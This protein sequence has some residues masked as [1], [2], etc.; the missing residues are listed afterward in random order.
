[1]NNVWVNAANHGF[2]P[3]AYIQAIPASLV[4]QY[5]LGG[6]QA[7]PAALIDTHGTRVS[8]EVWELFEATVAHLG[9]RPTLVEWDTSLPGLDVLLDEAQRARA[10][11]TSARRA[12]RQVA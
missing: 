10:I 9:T 7:T 4:G 6:F 12:A 1:M 8:A 5:H 2:D 11:A 3:R